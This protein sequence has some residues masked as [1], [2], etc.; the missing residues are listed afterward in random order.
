ML[1]FYIELGFCSTKLFRRATDAKCRLTTPKQLVDSQNVQPSIHM[2][3]CVHRENHLSEGNNGGPANCL[4]ETKPNQT[5]TFF[6][7]ETVP[8]GKFPSCTT[9]DDCTVENV[10]IFKILVVFSFLYKHSKAAIMTTKQYEIVASHK[11]EVKDI[12]F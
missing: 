9:D 6:H 10:L 12:N 7:C 4:R 11:S 8:L 1:D 3:H 5:R 2:E